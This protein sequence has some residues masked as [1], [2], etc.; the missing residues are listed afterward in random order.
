MNWVR[1]SLVIMLTLVC[2][3]SGVLPNR[4]VNAAS[5]NSLLL[6]STITPTIT[7]TSHDDSPYRINSTI[8]LSAAP[9]IG[10]TV[11]LTFTV[12]VIKLDASHPKEGLVKSKAWIDFY[13]TNTKGSFSEAY[14]SVQIPTEEVLGSGEF[15]WEGSYSKGLLRTA[16]ISEP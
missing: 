4:I 11:E 8:T 7:T 10:E 6:S 15:P 2:L 9:K 14:S 16:L 13:W 3:L 1:S 5:P 12:D